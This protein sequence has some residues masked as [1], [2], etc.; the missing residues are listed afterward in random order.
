M[1][2]LKRFNESDA[3]DYDFYSSIY[4]P[5]DKFVV[6]AYMIIE[7]SEKTIIVLNLQEREDTRSFFADGKIP[8]TFL[9]YKVILP[10]SQIEVL[11][12]VDNMEGFNWIKI[13]YWLVKNNPGLKIQRVKNSKRFSNNSTLHR[14]L[15][16]EMIDDNVRKYLSITD[17]DHRSVI[18]LNIISR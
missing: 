5:L 12:P 4:N 9:P 15:K 7:E 11:E 10:K 1:K 3:I 13:P 17:K 6:G 8:Y 14:S 16:P 18:N 2:Y